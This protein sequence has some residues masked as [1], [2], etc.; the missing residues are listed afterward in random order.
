MMGELP[1]EDKSMAT[2]EQFLPKIETMAQPLNGIEAEVLE[3]LEKGRTLDSHYDIKNSPV[4]TFMVKS[5]GFGEM[6]K[7]LKLS[8]EFFSG[9]LTAEALIANCDRNV[10][11]MIKN[12]IFQLFDSRKAALS[13]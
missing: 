12:A 8:K 2:L 13:Q 11:E 10:T 6:H 1:F 3:I 7:M 9:N 5:I 4:A